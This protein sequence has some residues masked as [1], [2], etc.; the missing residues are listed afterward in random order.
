MFVKVYTGLQ[1]AG[2]FG[3]NI[4]FFRLVIRFVK[5]GN[6]IMNSNLYQTRDENQL[7]V[8]VREEQ[9]SVAPENEAKVQIDVINESLIQIM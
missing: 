1:C 5:T 7:R 4:N 2:K 3:A 6:S 8:T 9:V